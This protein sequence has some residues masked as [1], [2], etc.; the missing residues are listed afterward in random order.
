MSG[1]ERLKREEFC[2]YLLVGCPKGP[3]QLATHIAPECRARRRHRCE[4]ANATAQVAHGARK[5]EA[6]VLDDLS[7][8]CATQARNLPKEG[9]AYFLFNSDV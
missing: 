2:A 6:R 1:H 8:V 9:T 4:F 3:W 7:A 5:G